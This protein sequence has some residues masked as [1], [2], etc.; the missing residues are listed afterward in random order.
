MKLITLDEL[1]YWWNNLGK[2]YMPEFGEFC[3]AYTSDGYKIL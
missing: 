2:Y 1:Y 3:D